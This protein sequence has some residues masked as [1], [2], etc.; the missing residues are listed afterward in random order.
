MTKNNSLHYL[1]QIFLMIVAAIIIV[2]F[3][4]REQTFSY[5]YTVGKPW[6]YGQIIATYDFPIYKS[7]D[8]IRAQR[9]SVRRLFQPYYNMDTTMLSTQ[10]QNLED[11][12]KAGK[13][14]K[15]P[16]EY[17]AYVARSLKN[18]YQTGIIDNEEYSALLDSGVNDIRAVSGTTALVRPVKSL[19]TTRSAYIHIFM[20]DT[21]HFR[22]ELLSQCNINNYLNVNMEEDR[23]KSREI[24]QDLMGSVSPASGMVQSGQKIIDRGDIVTAQTESILKSMKKESVKRHDNNDKERMLMLGQFLFVFMLLLVF[25][26]FL[27]TF[28]PDYLHSRSSML[29]LYFLIALFP[30]T[31]SL[32]ESHSGTS[33]Y[34][35]PYA[36]VPMFVRIFMD[37]RTA[38]VTHI[39]TVLMSSMSVHAPFE[40]VLV[41]FLS[42]FV[43]IYSI[44][45]LSSR[46]QLIRAALLITLSS[47]LIMFSYDLSQG[48]TPRTLDP[49]WYICICINGVLLLFAYPIMY[50][51]EKLFGFTSSVTLIEL[52]NV[53]TPLLRQMSKVAQ[54]TFNHSMQVANLATEVAAK[55]GAKVELVRTGALYHDIGKMKNAAF[56]TENQS[57]VNPH[58]SLSEERSAQIIIQHVP[59]GLEMAEK[60]HLPN[61]IKGFIATHHGR[62]KTKYFYINYINKHPDEPVNEE[63]FTYPGPN[64]STL[65]QAILMMADSVEAASRSL[66]VINDDTLRE[67][68]NN[69]I[70]S[71]VKEGYFRDCPITFHDIEVA[72]EQFI[73]SL[74]TIYHT[75][76][77]YPELKKPQQPAQDDR[78]PTFFGG[79]KNWNHIRRD[80]REQRQRRK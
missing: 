49:S 11:D 46:S 3:M 20:A 17:V 58:D 80:R 31:T 50:L 55:I 65:E 10:V 71:Q 35:I 59:D 40:F 73:S 22:H 32:V 78:G 2:F 53:N 28:R 74:K 79:Y 56:F 77:S 1:L 12:Y 9:D 51:I 36:M 5:N 26:Y 30:I 14:G 4:P 15:V 38:F 33:A 42:G 45:E 64:P 54:G 70:D 68:V 23:Q 41:Q 18:I 72:K 57:G 61:D 67:L 25:G 39:V 8:V 75:R 62:S 48:I 44:K 52:S 43:A 60:H 34:L 29:L 63:L 37:T 76:I 47:L 27:K 13:L 66:K 19:Y 7:D 69:I 21:V 6:K 24:M 16:V